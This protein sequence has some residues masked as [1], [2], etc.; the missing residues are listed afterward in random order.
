MESRQAGPVEAGLDIK[1]T[2]TVTRQTAEPPP[3]LSDAALAHIPLEI[4][5]CASC[6]D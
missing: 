4:T 3:E 6:S 1:S 2:L 5:P